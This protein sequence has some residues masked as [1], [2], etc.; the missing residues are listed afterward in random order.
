MTQQTWSLRD[1]TYLARREG[2]VAGKNP[3]HY[4][5]MHKELEIDDRRRV[6]KTWRGGSMALNGRRKRRWYFVDADKLTELDN[7]IVSVVANPIVFIAKTTQY[8]KTC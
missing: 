3:Q 4:R 7:L 8:R 2:L 5:P 1:D 6:M